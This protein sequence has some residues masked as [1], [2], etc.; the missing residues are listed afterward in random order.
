M[1]K[2]FEAALKGFGGDVVAM[3]P[4]NES[5]T[6][7]RAEVNAARGADPDSLFFVSYP[8]DGATLMR[9]W[10]SFGGTDNVV[11]SN[12]LRADEFVDA[13]GGQFLTKAVGIDNAQT[14]HPS[15]EA[16]N[17]EFQAKFDRPAQGPGLHLVYEAVAVT[18][19]AMQA[20]GE[21]TGEAIRDNIRMI[22]SPNGT[23][24]HPGLDGLRQGLDV[25]KAGQSVR[26][27]G[28]TGPLQFDEHAWSG[29]STMAPWPNRVS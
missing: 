9:E 29:A 16:F 21:A 14:E 26:Y 25:I 7:Y 5:Q 17:A 28:A 1:A 10:F 22:T 27:V 8:A 15:V 12:A 20:A 2:E 4:Y 3:V 18:L 19:L 24:F 23:Q 13:V 11:L 6:S